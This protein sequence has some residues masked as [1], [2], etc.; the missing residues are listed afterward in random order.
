MAEPASSGSRWMRY[1]P[2]DYVEAVK[3]STHIFGQYRENGRVTQWTDRETADAFPIWNQLKIPAPQPVA[4]PEVTAPNGTDYYLQPQPRP[5]ALDGPPITENILARGAQQR[6]RDFTTWFS[7]NPGYRVQKVLGWGGN[8]IAVHFRYHGTPPPPRSATTRLRARTIED[9]RN[10]VRDIVVKFPLGQW[11]SD[12]LHEE[13]KSTNKVRQSAHCIQILG[14]KETGRA[15]PNYT[16]PLFN[17]DSSPDDLSSGNATESLNDWRDRRDR[18]RTRRERRR[19]RKGSNKVAW[20]S[21]QYRQRKIKERNIKHKT[22]EE[23]RDFIILEYLENG[24]LGSLIERLAAAKSS[25]QDD[26]RVPNR[27]LW[28][29]WLCLVRACVAME[30]PPRKFH[31]D[32]KAPT[33]PEGAVPLDQV[34][35]NREKRALRDLGVTFYDPAEQTE[36]ERIFNIRGNNLIE[37]IPEFSQRRQNLVHFDIDP[38]NVFVDGIEF[39]GNNMGFWEDARNSA[40]YLRRQ[41]HEK[42]R[43]V[44]RVDPLDDR[45]PNEHAIVPKLKLADFGLADVIKTRKRNYYYYLRRNTGKSGYLAPEQFGAEWDSIPPEKDGSY[46]A[47][48]R[49][50]GFYGPHTNIWGIALT[51][52]MLITLCH[53][54]LPPARSNV[55]PN[56][57]GALMEDGAGNDWVDH[58][59]RM[60]IRNCLNHRP[61]DRPQLEVLLHQAIEKSNTV[62]DNEQSQVIRQWVHKCPPPGGGPPGGGPGGGAPGGGAPGGGAPRGGPNNHPPGNGAP[63]NNGPNSNPSSRPSN[64]GAPNSGLGNGLGGGAFGGGAPGGSPGG[65]PGSRL[66]NG[67]APGGSSF[68]NNPGNHPPDGG[69]P[70]S[71]G[72]NNNPGSRPPGD[73]APNSGPSSSPGSRPPGG[74]AL[75]SGPGNGPGSYPPGGGALNSGPGNGPGGGAPGG[76]APGGAPGGGT[77]SGSAPAPTPDPAN[78]ISPYPQPALPPP[79]LASA[80]LA[81]ARTYARFRST[82]PANYR[83]ID[84]YGVAGQC[85]ISALSDSLRHQLPATPGVDIPDRAALHQIYLEMRDA[86]DFDLLYQYPDVEPN[87]PIGPWS[88]DGLFMVLHEWGTRNGLRL[89]LGMVTQTNTVFETS[90]DDDDDDITIWVHN[91]DIHWRG[92]EPRP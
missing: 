70:G 54:P 12:T 88:A 87:S 11:A 27:V 60:T 52:W 76:G 40:R 66:L 74:G 86:G 47:D 7:R 51:M 56:S 16:L 77:G 48:S 39:S 43:D 5:P 32:R 36:R 65:N 91:I 46:I 72:P 3:A 55:A 89:R 59:L 14:P 71:D 15:P 25:G 42:Y 63:G 20:N 1:L 24:D 73:G 30:W 29:F 68:N 67:G 90:M 80:G 61:D 19:K 79:P 38:T 69:A 41:P 2:R 58:D 35:S 64:G 92:L 78:S 28:A 82:F 26:W 33:L 21:W 53:P 22:D 85:G 62:F 17:D 23:R 6:Y 49:V 34:K 75:N 18:A 83:A 10:P 31:P 81:A 13:I 8:G 45:A 9:P 37:N 4:V 57:Y 84:N 44:K 50:A